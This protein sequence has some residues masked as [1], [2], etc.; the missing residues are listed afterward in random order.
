M[1]IRLICVSDSDKHFSGAID[2]YS[3]RMGKSLEIVKIKPIKSLPTQQIIAKETQLM[4]SALTHAQG[5]KILL[6]FRGT[7][8]TTEQLVALTEKHPQLTCCI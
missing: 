7:P 3:K 8:Q 6:S 5:Y 2:E 1:K 4:L